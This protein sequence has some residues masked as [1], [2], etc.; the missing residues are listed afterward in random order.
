MAVALANTLDPITGEDQ[1]G[2]LDGLR[3]FLGEVPKEWREDGVDLNDV[4]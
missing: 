4:T 2:D 3:T 1:L